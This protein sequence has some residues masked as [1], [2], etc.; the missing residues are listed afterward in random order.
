MSFE[1]T[2]FDNVAFDR[3]NVLEEVVDRAV[4][5]DDDV[6]DDRTEADDKLEGYNDESI[7][8]NDS[9]DNNTITDCDAMQ[10]DDEE[11]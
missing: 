5:V 1:M 2:D 11:E 6:S 7:T 9:D 8:D 4:V 10:S 3:D